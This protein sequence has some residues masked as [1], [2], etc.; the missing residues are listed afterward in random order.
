MESFRPFSLP[1]FL[2]HLKSTAPNPLRFRS[3]GLTMKGKVEH[4]FYTAFCMSCAFAGWLEQRIDSMQAAR[5]E[6]RMA[7]SAQL[8]HGGLIS[9]RG[10]VAPV[11]DR[12][13]EDWSQGSSTSSFGRD[14]MGG[15]GYVGRR[16]SA[17]GLPSALG[18]LTLTVGRGH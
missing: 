13:S 5:M 14:S 16:G 6:Q 15:E 12:H 4:E 3:K 10:S 7:A 11:E 2:V 8:M 17:A 18:G 1:D 9:R